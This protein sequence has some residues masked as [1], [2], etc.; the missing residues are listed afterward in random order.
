[1][2]PHPHSQGYRIRTAGPADLDVIVAF[3][4]ALAEESE[5]R[6]LDLATLEAGVAAFLS[7]P[8]FGR[9]YVAERTGGGSET[10]ERSIAGQI[11]ITY[12]FSDWRNGPIWWLQSVYVAPEHRRRGAFRALYCELRS[13]ARKAGAVGLRLYVDRDNRP[14]QATY[15]AFGL[16]ESRYLMYEDLW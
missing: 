4:R 14:A 13:D 8:E 15:R 7:R 16:D 9:Y 12:E 1:M 10:S 11:M 6:D 2:Q 3:N 5:A